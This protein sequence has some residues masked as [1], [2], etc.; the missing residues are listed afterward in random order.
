[1]TR[2]EGLPH[3]RIEYGVYRDDQGV[4]H[5]AYYPKIGQGIVER[6]QIKG[7]REMAVRACKVAIDKWLEP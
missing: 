1:M 4:W 7:T 3:R 5:W 2:L 6:G